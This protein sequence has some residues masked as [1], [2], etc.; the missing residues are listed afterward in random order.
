MSDH[1]DPG[2]ENR[3][4]SGNGSRPP[5]G[6]LKAE[7]NSGSRDDRYPDE[8]FRFNDRAGDDRR[9]FDGRRSHRHDHSHRDNDRGH[10]DCPVHYDRRRREHESDD[11]R[12]Q[13]S[14]SRECQQY[15]K[16]GSTTHRRYEIVPNQKDSNVHPNAID[17]R[18]YARRMTKQTNGRNTESFDPASTLVRPDLRIHVGSSTSELPKL[19]HDD[20]VIVPELFGRQMIGHFTTSWSKK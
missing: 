3:S 15:P 10:S 17:P 20:V 13:R 19:K 5:W 12:R 2:K 14:R 4:V 16:H 18:N 1:Y 9:S 11:R 6:E 7:R 8:R